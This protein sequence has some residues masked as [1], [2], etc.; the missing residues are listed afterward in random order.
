M[1][2]F[3]VGDEKPPHADHRVSKTRTVA[4]IRYSSR[5]GRE[6]SATSVKMAGI[7]TSD[8]K[9]N[10]L[11][12]PLAWGVCVVAGGIVC[13]CWRHARRVNRRAPGSLEPLQ[14]HCYL[15]IIIQPK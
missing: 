3:N 15:V 14:R 7:C 9:A 13:G 5:G 2:G 6:A 1:A 11:D 8:V 10:E 4:G 12:S